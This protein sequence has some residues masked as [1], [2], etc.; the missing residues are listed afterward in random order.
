[1][2]F[3]LNQADR[4]ILL[5]SGGVLVGLILLA[6]VFSP[7][8]ESARTAPT[9]YS[10]ASEGAKAAYLLLQ[11]TG[12]RVERW[13][14]S[15]TE[16][17]REEGYTLI[18]TEPESVLTSE[19][20]AR[21]H[22]FVFDGGRLIAT[23][24]VAAT[25][26][27]HNASTW[28]VLGAME[29]QS[30]KAMVPSSLARVAG[31]ITLAPQAYW[32]GS[33]PALPLYGSKDNVVVVKY[34]HGKGEILWWASATPLTNAGLKE[35]G[36]LEFFLTCLGDK[37]ATRVLWDE[38]FHGRRRS[39]V[40]AMTATQIKWLFAQLALLALAV[41]ATYSRRSGPV[42]APA[43]E[44]RLSPLEF[45]D[46]LG[47]LYQRANATAVAVDVAY[48]R[49]RHLLVRR[50]GMARDISVEDLENAVRV[51]WGLPAPDFATTLKE[52]EAGRFYADLPEKEALR[53]V[54]SLHDYGLKLKLI[55]ASRVE[56]P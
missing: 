47:G 18:L 13:E 20:R 17:P 36:N 35:A 24:P 6:L 10:S 7:P 28:N 51:R 2:S 41:L 23:G 12:Y 38:Y 15:P 32:S 55:P 30:F 14:R 52:C 34:Q 54:R 42:R 49:F 29:W 39:L 27:P 19:E 44:S 11:A 26:L 46:T 4:K 50:L 21:L 33:S 3:K 5:V 22:R 1:M 56:K 45:V 8:T 25:M 53:L 43:A 9:T 16:L 31:E 40:T 37:Q 48:R